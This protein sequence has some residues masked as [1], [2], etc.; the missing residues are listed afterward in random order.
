MADDGQVSVVAT[1]RRARRNYA[2]VDTFEAG[3]VLLGSEVK[4]LREGKMELKD[5]YADIR[6]GE[7]FLVGAHISPY[8]FAREGG[9]DPERERK[10]LLHRREIDRIA[11]SVAEKGLTLIPLKVYFRDGKAKVELALARG[12]TTV[13]KRQ[14]LRDREHT[15]EM[16]RAARRRRT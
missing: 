1:N 8:D 4:S 2:V 11:G 5:S 7:A 16:E 14:T 9:H 13:D 12:K 10:L 3:M 15:R 6:H